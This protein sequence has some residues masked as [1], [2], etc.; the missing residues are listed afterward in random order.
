QREADKC[1]DERTFS[2]HVVELFQRHLGHLV[3]RA[4][5][6]EQELVHQ[7]QRRFETAERDR[8]R[9][10]V[11]IREPMAGICKVCHRMPN[12]SQCPRRASPTPVRRVSGNKRIARIRAISDRTAARAPGAAFDSTKNE[13]KQSSGPNVNPMPNAAPMSAM[14]RDR[15]SNV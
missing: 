12:F 2:E 8:S 9:K 3:Y 1:K 6:R 5:A 10:N 4:A 15:F 13:A 11:R 7:R 14:P